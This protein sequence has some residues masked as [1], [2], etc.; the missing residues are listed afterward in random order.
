VSYPKTQ[1]VCACSAGLYCDPCLK[2]SN[3]GRNW[4]WWTAALL[5]LTTIG[6]IYKITKTEFKRRW[7]LYIM[8]TVTFITLISYV[9]MASGHGYFYTNGGSSFSPAYTRVT[10][11][12]Q[13]I[14]WAITIP[15]LSLVLGRFGEIATGNIYMLVVFMWVTIALGFL[16]SAVGNAARYAYFAVG[17]LTFVPALKIILDSHPKDVLKANSYFGKFK[18]I[19]LISWIIYPIIWILGTG[20]GAICV[21]TEIMSYCVLDVLSKIFVAWTVFFYSE[22]LPSLEWE[23]VLPLAQNVVDLSRKVMAASGSSFL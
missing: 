3:S 8:S 20:A 14:Q 13:Y 10:S 7:A 2:R 21:D 1:T 17:V 23:Q 16:A 5:V 4:Q 6:L 18:W 12:I 15:L 19:T 11:W 9:L 22:T